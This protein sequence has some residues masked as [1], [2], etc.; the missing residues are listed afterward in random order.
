MAKLIFIHCLK[1][2][3]AIGS[4]SN[5]LKPSDEHLRMLRSVYAVLDRKL[6][7]KA[8]ASSVSLL[9]SDMLN[10]A[11]KSDLFAQFQ[12]IRCLL[13]SVVDILGAQL[14][15]GFQFVKAIIKAHSGT[16]N[17]IASAN[18]T[19]RLIFECTL[20][21]TRTVPSL[22]AVLEAAAPRSGNTKSSMN[23]FDSVNDGEMQG[24][25]RSM[26]GLRKSILTWC[27]TDLCRLYHKKVS[28]EE[29]ARCSD[30]YYE[31]GAVTRGPGAP[32]Y[33]SVLSEA[34]TSQGE[35]DRS[36]SFHKMMTFIRCV[37]FLSL[38]SSKELETFASTGEDNM[39]S[40]RYCRIDFCCCFGIN[41]DDEM[42]RIVLSSNSLTSGTAL[43][44]IENLILRCGGSSTAEIRCNAK[45][46]WDMYRLAEYSPEFRSDAFGRNG[47]VS[48]SD[49]DSESFVDDEQY[50]RK[51]RKL[52]GDQ[53]CH[54]MSFD[55]SK[56]PR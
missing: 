51:R 17:N 30:T 10:S 1:G 13:E 12:N 4:I 20:L 21:V 8:L 6:A 43:S 54:A 29:Q 38:P 33:S 16:S 18:S 22:Q 53:S 48:S 24:F 14:F 36:S 32:D 28:Q 35:D 23:D 55:K 50:G 11:S 47:S 41:I 15:D 9:T 52:D 26:V 45:T 19:A 42:L 3:C 25:R 2:E 31:R 7:A 37:L 34:K 5:A 44:I 39:Q 40:G 49:D 27:L 46:V 56:L